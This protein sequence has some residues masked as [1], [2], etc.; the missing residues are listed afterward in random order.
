MAENFK[1]CPNCGAPLRSGVK[2]CPKCG[3]NLQTYQVKSNPTSA[4]SVKDTVTENINKAKANITNSET[5]QKAKENIAKSETYQKAKQTAKTSNQKFK[6]LPKKQQQKVLGIGFVVLLLLVFGFV[7]HHNSLKVQLV[8]HDVWYLVEDNDDPSYPDGPLFAQAIA[9]KFQK[10]GSV[11]EDY[12]AGVEQAP[13]FE[14][15][16]RWQV[17]DQTIIFDGGD[18][19]DNIKIDHKAKVDYETAK[20]E[21]NKTYKGYRVSF[22]D[23]DDHKHVQG[24]LVHE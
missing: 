8:S 2:F 24:Y 15:Q 14:N 16:R 23:H 5:Y 6:K 18:N 10:N 12:Y 9:L 22:R 21:K 19:F 4:S 13:N 17:K 7:H 3:T 1:F 11:A 20:F